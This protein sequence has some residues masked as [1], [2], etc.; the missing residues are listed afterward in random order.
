MEKQLSPETF[1]GEN[2]IGLHYEQLLNIFGER[3]KTALVEG[4]KNHPDVRT[5]ELQVIHQGEKAITLAKSKND[6]MAF[7]F[8]RDSGGLI[9]EVNYFTDEMDKKYPDEFSEQ[10]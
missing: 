6:R 4:L 7:T 5:E 2:Y 3:L 1:G 10:K 8:Y 9:Y